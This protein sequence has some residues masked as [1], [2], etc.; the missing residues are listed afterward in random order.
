LVEFSLCWSKQ[1]CDRHLFCMGIERRAE[2]LTE[3]WSFSGL[4]QD[5]AK[6]WGLLLVGSKWL[7]NVASADVAWQVTCCWWHIQLWAI[8]SWLPLW[9]AGSANSPIRL[10][11]NNG[12]IV[13]LYCKCLSYTVVY[14]M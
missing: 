10:I 2:D 1:T 9:G 11:Q 8:V 6:C 4:I 7:N 12:A 3:M 5:M 14:W 13:I